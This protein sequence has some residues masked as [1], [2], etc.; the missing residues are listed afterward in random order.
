MKIT[1]ARIRNFRCIQELDLDLDDTTVFVGP[2]NEGKTAILDALRLVLTRRWGQRGTGFNEYDIYL[3]S[4][5]DDAKKSPGATIE[6]ECKE[7]V[8][9]EWPQSL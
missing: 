6:I 2:N 9:G 5:N 8:A 7:T 3:S 4:P 1:R